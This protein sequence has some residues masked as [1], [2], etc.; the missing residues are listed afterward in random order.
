MSDFDTITAILSKAGQPWHH[1]CQI[2]ADGAF[3]VLVLD[4]T[5]DGGRNVGLMWFNLKTGEFIKANT[6]WLDP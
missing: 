3:K 4:G 2:G 6:R 5:Q 1:Y